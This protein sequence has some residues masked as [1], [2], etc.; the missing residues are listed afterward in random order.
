VI[1]L[2]DVTIVAFDCAS[3]ELTKYALEKTLA[4]ITPY[5][6]LVFTDQRKYFADLDCEIHNVVK[7][8][9]LDDAERCL[10][11]EIPNHITTSHLLTVEWDGWVLDGNIWNDSWLRY[12][13]IGAPW[14]WHEKDQVG[15]G[16]FS[17][18]SANLMRCLQSYPFKLP[19]DDTICRVIKPANYNFAP[20]EIAEKFSLEHGPYQE[21]F[22][23]H[24]MR[25]WVRLLP[26]DEV[27]EIL[28]LAN[29]YTK[30][31]PG[32]EDLMNA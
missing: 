4:E 11:Y 26:R 28:K 5:K 21:T 22:G 12:D 6:T 2:P 27:K 19:T 8:R 24:D 20:V 3:Y 23:F 15:N 14:W 16:G 17:L 10:W 7:F 1:S 29:S 18:R 32:F 9:N 30:S 13:W 25:N 31:K